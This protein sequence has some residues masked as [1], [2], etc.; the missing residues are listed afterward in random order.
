[1]GEDIVSGV[2]LLGVEQSFPNESFLHTHT[3]TRIALNPLP[4]N[5]APG[6]EDLS[7]VWGQQWE[8]GISKN[9]MQ[10]SCANCY[11]STMAYFGSGCFTYYVLQIQIWRL[12]ILTLFFPTFSGEGVD[13]SD[14][15]KENTLSQLVK[16]EISLSLTRKYDL[17]EGEEQDIKGLMMKYVYFYRT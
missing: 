13:P 4:W 5:S 10:L 6:L 3:H 11:S 8:Q 12:T 14:P 7:Q 1:M 17:R 9:Y 16:T 15:N 2:K